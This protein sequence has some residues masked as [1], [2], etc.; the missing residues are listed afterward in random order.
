MRAGC[1]RLRAEHIVPDKTVIVTDALRR[2]WDTELTIR[3]IAVRPGPEVAEAVDA[4][5]FDRFAPL[6]YS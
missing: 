6:T 5:H 1:S 2:I 4:L 3:V